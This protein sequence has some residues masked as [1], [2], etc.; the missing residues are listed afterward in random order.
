MHNRVKADVFVPAGGR[1]NTIHAGNWDAFL[2]PETGVPS[3]PLIVEGA[4]IFITKEARQNLFDRAKVILVK[5]SSANKCGVITSSFEI[6][7]SML[8]D[9]KEFLGNKEEI[10]KDVLQR[11]RELAGLEAQLLFREYRNYQGSLPHFSERISQAISRTCAAIRASLN[12]VERGSERYQKLLPL[13]MEHLP[14][15]LAEIAG[16][17]VNERIPLDYLRN[18][19]ASILASKL[20]YRE[21]IH[22]CESMPADKLPTIAMLYLDEEKNVQQLI[23]NVRAAGGMS[24]ENESKVIDLLTRGGVRSSLRL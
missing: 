3:S 7:A 1:P 8:V 6:C 20:L 9:E 4:N 2:D 17:R 19:F 11:L 24:K 18:A 15:K 13:F 21:G 23:R 5:D 10:V 16:D 14:A 22:F 12:D